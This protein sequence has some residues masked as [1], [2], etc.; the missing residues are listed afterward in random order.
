M[1]TTRLLWITMGVFGF[2]SIGEAEAR[3]KDAP[4]RPPNV[5]FIAIDDLNDWVGVLGGHPQARTPNLDRLAKK[6]LLFTRAY[7]AAPAC[8]PSRTAILT[9]L[10]PST[11]GVYHNDQPWRP[12]L[13]DAVT[14][15]AYLLRNGYLVWGGGKIFHGG[16]PDVKAWSESFQGKPKL[17]LPKLPAR[18]IG[19][20]MQWGP[21]DAGDDVMRDTRL[22]DWAIDKLK[23]KHE[24]P[25]FLAVGYQKPHLP[26]YAPK[27]YFDM[28][29]LDK[30]QLPKVLDSDL[31]DVPPA[32]IK[33]AKA[34]G[35]HRKI[36]E[37][38]LWKEAVQAY[39][40]CATYMDAQL[41]RLLDA[42]EE[43]GQADNTIIIL[44]SDHGWSHG[45]KQH[46]RKFSL[47]EQD[48][49]V[50]FMIAARGLTT[51]RTRCQ[52]TVSL[53]DLY[54]TV[55]DLCGLPSKKGLEGHSLLPLLRNPQTAWDQPAVTTH[56]RNNHSIRTEK[57]RLIRYKDGSEE[58]YDHDE[59]PLEWK[60][61]AK[62]P[63]F[64][65]VRERL[66]AQLP[67]V[68]AVDAASAK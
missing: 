23:T 40:A 9:G 46:W 51:P 36:T 3:A 8:N 67:K 56:G 37:A 52:R 48:C 5:L 24:R 22:T 34:Q 10:R 13:P 35:D 64:Q 57:W 59:D 55:I 18:G 41:G 54:P 42:L 68:N 19:G 16:Y 58:L 62:E 63:R 60:N 4:Q 25:F 11:S 28:H 53:L 1:K 45:Q 17:P 49:R 26:W 66:A 6:C 21:L 2:V 47:W 29:P 20:N 43:S 61:L 15:P 14:L 27:K 65:S 33:M 12:A 31:D 32:G 50:V 38:G 7:C 39:L 30:I 44:W